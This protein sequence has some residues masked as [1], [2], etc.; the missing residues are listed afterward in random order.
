ML[1]RIY[2]VKPTIAKN[3]IFVEMKDCYIMKSFEYFASMLIFSRVNCVEISQP[4]LKAHSLL[5]G[6][7]CLVQLC[8]HSQ[9]QPVS[10]FLDY[11]NF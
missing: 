9:R 2:N 5:L 10:T 8:T 6:F 11:V 1:L 4:S 7:Y 3:V